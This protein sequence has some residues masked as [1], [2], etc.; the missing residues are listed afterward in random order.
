MSDYDTRNLV[1]V[2]VAKVAAA[3][4][5]CISGFSVTRDPRGFR[6]AFEGYDGTTLYRSP[7]SISETKLVCTSKPELLIER[8]LRL[9]VASHR[10]RLHGKKEDQAARKE[11]L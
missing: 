11:A 6:V 5:D 10:R 2:A 9:R 8:V 3:N 7:V 4:P 1:F